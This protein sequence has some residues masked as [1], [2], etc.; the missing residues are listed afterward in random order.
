MIN[1][2]KNI[3][4]VV[5]LVSLI[6]SIIYC[7]T[8]NK[9]YSYNESKHQTTCD[10]LYNVIETTANSYDSLRI[11]GDSLYAFQRSSYD[12]LNELYHIKINTHKEQV[13]V[14]YKD[15]TV[16]RYVEDT[17]EEHEHQ[18]EYIEKEVLKEVVKVIHDTIN[19]TKTD[20][21]YKE[22][23]IEV[24]NTETNDNKNVVDNGDLFN[25]YVDGNVKGN[26]DY[27]LIP[28]IGAGIIFKE[29]FYGQVGIDYDKGNVNPNIKLGVRLKVF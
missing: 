10:S 22:N 13:T 21:V 12:S 6:I 7:F 15:S 27:D 23:K 16:I 3:A 29:K 8:L 26:L 1:K 11:Y 2:V 25:I 4:L 5:L 18:V 20:T 24:S 9:K 14:I 17:K 19:V 28:E